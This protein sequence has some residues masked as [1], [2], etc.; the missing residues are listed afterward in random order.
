MVIPM[1]QWILFIAILF[2]TSTSL[3]AQWQVMNNGVIGDL[4]DVCF[5]DRD[6]GYLVGGYTVLHEGEGWI[7]RTLDG[8][9]S[10]E[11][12]QRFHAEI[13]TCSFIDDVTGFISFNS[14]CCSS[15]VPGHIHKTTDSGQTW[16]EVSSGWVVTDIWFVDDSTAWGVGD[17]IL[18][19]VNSGDS[20]KSVME[21]VSLTSL[22]FIDHKTG[23]AV[24][25]DTGGRGVIL[26]TNDCGDNWSVAVDSLS[27]ALESLFFKDG[28]CWA[29]GQS[30]MV[31]RN[32]DVSAGV[33]ATGY[34]HPVDFQLFQNYPNP[35]NQL[36][37]INY[38]R[39]HRL[40]YQ[41][42]A[43]LD[44]RWQ[45]LFQNRCQQ[46]RTATNGMPVHLPAVC[47]FTFCQWVILF[48]QRNSF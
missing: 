3:S 5:I 27:G 10:W 24:A 48:R 32:D 43:L 33:T 2:V 40:N 12:A 17:G 37:I 39:Q 31:L 45:R 7:F 22:Y 42:I 47:I 35:F 9:E 20:W 15:W 8:G 16:H 11:L 25:V 41:S 23:W 46:V 44:G 30:G 38:Q 36:T 29:V 21:G 19:T 6:N 18:S 4:N 13:M 1:I 14:V 28:Y 26:E 34:H